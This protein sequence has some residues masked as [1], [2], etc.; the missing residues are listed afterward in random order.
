MYFCL[1]HQDPWMLHRDS[2]D[3]DQIMQMPCIRWHYMLQNTCLHRSNIMLHI[4]KSILGRRSNL[5]RIPFTQWTWFKLTI[6]NN[7]L[8]LLSCCYANLQIIVRMPFVVNLL[9]A[10]VQ[11]VVFKRGY[12]VICMQHLHKGRVL[13]GQ[14]ENAFFC[15]ILRLHKAGINCWNASC[16]RF[17]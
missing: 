15:E 9:K 1:F 6:R 17:Q 14:L 10:I 3:S 13:S 12:F 8:F 4:H 11:I 2:E 7:I 16:H 5:G